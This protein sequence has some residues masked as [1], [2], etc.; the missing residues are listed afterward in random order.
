M[1][2]S[3]SMF[4]DG[5][6]GGFTLSPM[7]NSWNSI[8]TIWKFCAFSAPI[9]HLSTGI[10]QFEISIQNM[11]SCLASQ[12]VDT[13]SSQKRPCF[14]LAFSWNNKIC[15]W[16]CHGFEEIAR[17][18]RWFWFPSCH[19]IWVKI[20]GKKLGKK[21]QKSLIC[22]AWIWSYSKRKPPWLCYDIEWMTL[23]GEGSPSIHQQTYPENPDP[24]IQWLF[25]GPIHP[26][27]IQVHTPPWKGPIADS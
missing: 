4:V 11:A 24:S 14:F 25:W 21:S 26:C 22:T 7:I 23:D 3:A 18:T 17:M 12:I 9:V 15:T 20:C 19:P 13:K 2:F 27:Y 5:R 16:T 8:K 1:Q 6:I 10:W